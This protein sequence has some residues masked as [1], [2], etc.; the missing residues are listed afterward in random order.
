MK[1]KIYPTSLYKSLSGDLTRFSICGYTT[2]TLFRGCILEYGAELANTVEES[3]FVFV[4]VTYLG[5]EFEFDVELFN[6]IKKNNKPIVIVDYTES[7]GQDA[8]RLLEYNLYGYKIEHEALL[9]SNNL[10]LMHE[11]LLDYDNI[12]CY[13]KRELSSSLDYSN[14]RFRVLPIEFINDIS[15]PP[16]TPDTESD[17]YNRPILYNFI[18]GYS[19]ISR[20]ILQ[21]ELM[22]NFLKFNCDLALSYK[23]AYSYIIEERRRW[24]TLLI[25]QG[26]FERVDIQKLYELQYKS[27]AIIDMYGAGL[28][29]FRNMESFHNCMSFK[30]DP[31]KLINTYE[32]INDVNCVFLPNV[33]NSNLIDEVK[34]CQILLD[35]KNN[36]KAYR[37]YLESINMSYKYAPK[38]YVPNHIIANILK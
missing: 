31:S 33:A 18:W 15:P 30:Q 16:Y 38:N 14:V 25:C 28:K 19:N 34:S 8:Q 20:P 27:R 17:Y 5:T 6:K 1:P 29:C 24:Y 23:Q 13:F 11:C 35:Y 2:H 36:G 32:W 4:F 26:W 37:I 7:G 22:K 10:K 3:D 21:G 9:Q 12:I